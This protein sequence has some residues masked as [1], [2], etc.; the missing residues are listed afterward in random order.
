M[1]SYLVERVHRLLGLF[2]RYRKAVDEGEARR[3]IEDDFRA[4]VEALLLEVGKIESRRGKNIEALQEG[5]EERHRIARELHDGPAQDM[6][7]ILAWARILE[8]SV[9]SDP[10]AARTEIAEIRKLAKVG[11][12]GIRAIL[13]NLRP[14]ILEDLGLEAAVVA[15]LDRLRSIRP[16]ESTVI[17][18]AGVAEKL[19]GTE[20]IHLFR[21]L[22]EAAS[23]AVRHGEPR[24]LRIRGVRREGGVI[25][26]VED[27]GRGGI[28]EISEEQL[29]GAGRHG[30]L[31][32][33]ERAEAL[34]GRIEFLAR[35]GGGTLVRIEMGRTGD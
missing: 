15:H 1:A 9:R 34:G 33:K 2:D 27:D 3:G 17:F 28:E 22:S 4:E 20:E 7:A 19:G 10:E 16:F 13:L 24:F 12:E 14:P 25:F 35:P 32:M 21:I 31:S 18:E 26:E 8:E 11:L 30:I 5:E 23:N 6:A 29:M